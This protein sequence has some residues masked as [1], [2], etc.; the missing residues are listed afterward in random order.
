MLTIDYPPNATGGEG[1]VAE[2]IAHLLQSKGIDIEVVAPEKK[3]CFNYDQNNPIKIHR[4]KI[5]GKTFLTKIPSFILS[6]RKIVKNFDGDIIYTLRPCIN[7]KRLKT[8]FHMHT[9]RY[10][11]AKG[12]FKSKKY[13]SAVLN[14]LYIPFDLWMC[15][16]CQKLI[17]LTK[18][19]QNDINPF[20]KKNFYQKIYI[21]ENGID[22]FFFR[23]IKKKEFNSQKI[24]FIGRLDSR[25]GIFTLLNSFNQILKQNK[26]PIL[27]IAGEGP[28]KKPILQFIKKKKIQDNV[29]LLDKIPF[30]KI[31]EVYNNH[32]L[33]VVPSLYES[34]GMVILE[35]M[36]C[37]TPVISSDVCVDL[38]QPMFKSGNIH[39]LKQS[40]KNFIFDYKELHK[41]SEFGLTKANNYSWDAIIKKLIQVLTSKGY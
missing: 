12:C 29:F 34:F 39:E 18:K 36:A 17:I 7:N 8:I 40:I 41:L 33:T 15:S 9:T 26:G 20:F 10:G 31:P 37:G 2:K 19:M 27:S 11:E 23:P 16:K 13:L 24:L 6:T 30:H 28:L 38:G 22:H 14:F 4:V 25:K 32:D 3:G 35:S 1:I 21:V 5:F